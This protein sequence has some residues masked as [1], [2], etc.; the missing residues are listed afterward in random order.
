MPQRRSWEDL[1]ENE[2]GP[3]GKVFC[4]MLGEFDKQKIL[5][6]LLMH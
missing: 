5:A 4:F 1:K 6:I 2:R 3:G